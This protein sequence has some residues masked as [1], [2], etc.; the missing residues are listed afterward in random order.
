MA[1]I[2]AIYVSLGKPLLANI[3]WSISNLA[4]FS[5]N[6]VISEYEMAMLF[7]VYEIIAIYGI[8]N[9]KYKKVVN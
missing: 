1:I 8:Y 9:L 2:G 5:Y 6:F 7:G 3:I 4:I